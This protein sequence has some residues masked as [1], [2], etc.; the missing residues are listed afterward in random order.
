[1]HSPELTPQKASLS[2]LVATEVRAEM[3]R[4]GRKRSEFARVIGVSAVTASRA[5]WGHRALGLGELE[6]VAQWLGVEAGSLIA[7]AEAHR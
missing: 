5:L 2:V 4:Q 7:R 1:M 3:A 6:H